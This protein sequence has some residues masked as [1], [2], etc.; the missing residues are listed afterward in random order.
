MDNIENSSAEIIIDSNNYG[1]ANFWKQGDSISHFVVIVLL[2][3][4][5]VSWTQIVIK[6]IATLKRKKTSLAIENFW[7][8]KS[9]NEA[10]KN[11]SNET[12]ADN[13]FT[14]LAKEALESTQRFDDH[15]IGSIANNLNRDEFITKALRQSIN[16]SMAKMESGLT[17]LASIGAISPF[18][19]L[20]GTVYGIYNALLGISSAGNASLNT[21][22]GPVGEALIMTAIGLFVAIPAVLA[23]NSFVRF[24]RLELM[25]LDGFA[26]D[27]QSY[28]STGVTL[29]NKKSGK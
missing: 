10:V 9:I 29:S 7:N 17:L 21:V 28:L 2:I 8:S 6:T 18:V 27:L 12:E 13:S 16:R 1:L 26:H 19:G 20:F 5:I 3:M 24:N 22:S 15:K 23:Y 14:N 11:I 4:S 25:E